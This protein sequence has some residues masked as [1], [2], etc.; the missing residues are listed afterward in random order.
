MKVDQLPNPIEMLSYTFYCQQFALGVFFEY[1]DFINWIEETNEYKRVPSP[2]VESLKYAV[3]GILS[4]VVFSVGAAFFPISYCFTDEYSDSSLGYKLVYANMS[5]LFCRYFYYTAF[6]F[7][8][9]TVIASGFG[10]NGRKE[11]SD[12]DVVD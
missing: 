4:I 5:G 12:S 3:Y 9:G 2:V 7:Q 11:V 10:Y 1:R 6:L 8:T